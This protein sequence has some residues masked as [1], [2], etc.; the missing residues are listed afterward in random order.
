MWVKS[1]GQV[2]TEMVGKENEG[3]IPHKDIV[4]RTVNTH[5]LYKEF[6]S[7]FPKSNRQRQKPLQ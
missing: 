3:E 5:E 7:K 4:M 2:L 1:R 6:I